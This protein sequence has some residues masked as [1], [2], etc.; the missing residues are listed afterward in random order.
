MVILVAIFNAIIAIIPSL[1]SYFSRK[2]AVT[3]ATV[4]AFVLLTGALLV[5]IQALL[6]SL[7]S[8]LAPPGSITSY[9]GMFVP[10]DLPLCISV[11]VS[12]R[13]AKAAYSIAMDKVR[14]IATAN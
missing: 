9:L 1:A 5:A 3:A 11:L 4:G 10:G 7:V 2:A 6:N 14:V 13:A 12:A 8:W